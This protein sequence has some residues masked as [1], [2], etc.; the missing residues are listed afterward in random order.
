MKIHGSKQKLN[1]AVVIVRPVSPSTVIKSIYWSIYTMPVLMTPIYSRY[2]VYRAYCH[3]TAGYQK[4]TCICSHKYS[5]TY[6]IYI[7][8]RVRLDRVSVTNVQHP[9]NNMYIAAHALN[10]WVGSSGYC[11]YITD[12][13][14]RLSGIPVHCQLQY[15]ECG[16]TVTMSDIILQLPFLHHHMLSRGFKC[17]TH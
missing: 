12:I 13:I 15:I 2:H 7:D 16:L 6:N 5:S 14:K 17:T 10:V 11:Y 3:R 9:T 8:T 4:C 1:G